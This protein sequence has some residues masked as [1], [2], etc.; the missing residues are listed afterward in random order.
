MDKYSTS[1]WYKDIVFFLLNF[2]CPLD[3]D[4]KRIRSLKMKDHKYG[5]VDQISF[6][7]DPRG[8]LLRCINQNEVDME[9]AY[10]HSGACGGQNWKPITLKI[11]RAG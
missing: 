11:L 2:Q 5:I 9:I 1:V 3:Y 4:R 7:K 10:L 8:M 6:W